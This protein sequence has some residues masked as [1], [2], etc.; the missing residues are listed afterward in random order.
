MSYLIDFVARSLFEYEQ[1]DSHEYPGADGWDGPLL[2]DRGRKY[3]RD[4]AR[5]MLRAMRE[6]PENPGPRYTAG[7][8]SRRNHEAM[9]D[10]ALS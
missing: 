3:Y 4:A 10:D 2:N 1:P 5:K 8:Y 6:L 7:E 9:I